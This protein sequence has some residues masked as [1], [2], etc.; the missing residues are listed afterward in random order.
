MTATKLAQLLLAMLLTLTACG[1][2]STVG[3]RSSETP[4]MQTSPTSESSQE[5]QSQLT[6]HVEPGQDAQPREWTLHCDPP[7]GSHP[8]PEAACAALAAA[9]DPF[10]P[11]PPDAIC[12]Q[13]Y[14]GPQT[15]TLEG[16]WRGE[17]VHATY[18]RK[19]GCEI[20]R[21][22]AIKAALQPLQRDGTSASPTGSQPGLD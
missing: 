1:K 14:G 10:K 2:G 12:T 19:N 13:I 4:T 5:P 16:T 7:G 11:V 15:A 6:V 3:D 17:R 22:E 20:H 18:N 21:W 9:S 8:A